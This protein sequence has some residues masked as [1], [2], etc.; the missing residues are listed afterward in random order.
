MVTT[1]HE[2]TKLFKFATS[3]TQFSYT[4]A[5]NFRNDRRKAVTHIQQIQE[6]WEI[7]PS[8][9]SVA[10]LYDINGQFS[11]LFTFYQ[12]TQEYQQIL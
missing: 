1:L 11:S 10:K 9:N 3:S 4:Y 12:Y 6:V 8:R 5:L 2:A 7:E